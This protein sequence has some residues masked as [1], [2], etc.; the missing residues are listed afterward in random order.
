MNRL[1]SRLICGLVLAGIG[2][3]T[4][5]DV[6]T[7]GPTDNGA[8]Q[9]V[10]NINVG[11][12]GVEGPAVTIA[13]NAVAVDAA[14]NRL[15]FAVPQAGGTEIRSLNYSTTGN[16]SSFLSVPGHRIT[17]LELDSSG[18]ARL[19]AVSIRESDQQP[20]LTPISLSSPA[21]GTSL[22][23]SGP[24]VMG[25]S[26]FRPSDDR[27][28]LLKQVGTVQSLEIIDA[29]TGVQTSL[30]VPAGNRIGEL[31]QHPQSNSLYALVDQESDLS[32]HVALLVTGASLSLGPLGPTD[33]GCCFVLAGPAMIDA[34]ANRLY[35]LARDRTGTTPTLPVVVSFD[36]ATGARDLE[37][38][39]R[40]N[41]LFG[42]SGVNLPEL[43]SDSFE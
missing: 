29:N 9:R 39:K 21:F 40:A 43:F 26:A 38:L 27:F 22:P 16:H 18:A 36:L 15:Y 13:G 19:L 28:F 31:V 30:A 11:A 3:W 34:G 33:T 10:S 37:S 25:V 17:H 14:S 1:L 32:T 5:A 12:L 20:V 23:L 7:Y 35:A 8:G 4:L 42:D 24:F 41:A 6:F 2:G